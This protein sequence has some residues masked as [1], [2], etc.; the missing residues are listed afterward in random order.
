MDYVRS[1]NSS[2]DFEK[3]KS[4]TLTRAFSEADCMDKRDSFE[5]G[6]GTI[7]AVAGALCVSLIILS[8]IKTGGGK[9]V[10][11]TTVVINERR[12]ER[13]IVFCSGS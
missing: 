8:R 3:W 1:L 11:V 9:V 13:R 4:L 2:L 5:A 7:L 6:E 12:W 10:V